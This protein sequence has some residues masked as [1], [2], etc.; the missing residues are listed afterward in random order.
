M[1]DNCEKLTKTILSLS[2]TL[3]VLDSFHHTLDEKNIVV[4]KLSLQ[5][6]KIYDENFEIGWKRYKDGEV[7]AK[8]P[9][10]LGEIRSW[11]P[12]PKGG[13][14]YAVIYPDGSNSSSN[15]DKNGVYHDEIR[16][17][18]Y[19]KRI[20]IDNRGFVTL[21]KI[22][23]QEKQRDVYVVSR[24][25]VETKYDFGKFDETDYMV[26]KQGLALL[27]NS[28]NPDGSNKLSVRLN[29]KTIITTFDEI[30]LVPRTFIDYWHPIGIYPEG[31][32]ATRYRN[33][34]DPNCRTEFVGVYRNG[35]EF[36]GKPE[37]VGASPFGIAMEYMNGLYLNGEEL[38]IFPY[39][40]KE[41]KADY[42]PYKDGIIIKEDNKFVFYET[43]KHRTGIRMGV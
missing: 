34:Y 29:G 31:V 3:K 42:Y 1:T 33:I 12:H 40:N 10:N 24:D 5:V 39:K 43:A 2:T 19:K 9:K 36:L 7:V 6:E 8:C 41:G 4:A 14:M 16:V 28:S 37:S 11:R 32:V 38:N 23:D 26:T 25:G 15:K 35:N 20:E 13:I 18:S 21:S 17:G 30:K 22:F 27:K